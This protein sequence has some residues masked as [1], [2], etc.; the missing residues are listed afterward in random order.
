MNFTFLAVVILK[1][2]NYSSMA[3]TIL[4]VFDV[5]DSAAFALHTTTTK[6]R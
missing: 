6:S 4:G 3:A 1:S 5:A 2:P